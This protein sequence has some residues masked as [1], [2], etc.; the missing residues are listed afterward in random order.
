[1][2]HGD[3]TDN[4][5]QRLRQL[6]TY[7][8]E[9]PVTGPSVG[10]APSRTPAA[11]LHLATLDHITASYAEVVEH[12]RSA[13]PDAG[14]APARADAVY[15][16]AREHTAHADEAVQQRA[17]VIEYRQYLEHAI[18]AGDWRKVIRPHRC[19]E[20][21][22][23]GLMWKDEMQRVLCTNTRCVDRDGFS[24][25]VTLSRLAHEHVAKQK[26]LQQVSAT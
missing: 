15:D 20:C 10:H 5:T 2:N 11:P 7:F 4:A 6:S 9:H 19:P 17:A 25:T 18:R 12:T 14:P 23:F 8:R 16:W 3:D 26:S 1:M 24:T 21:R 22:T 13:N